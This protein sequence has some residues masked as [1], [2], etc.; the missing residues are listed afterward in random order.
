MQKATIGGHVCVRVTDRGA[1]NRCKIVERYRSIQ[2]GEV[3]VPNG[4]TSA[5]KWFGA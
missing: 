4:S 3:H 2:I 1:T 5:R